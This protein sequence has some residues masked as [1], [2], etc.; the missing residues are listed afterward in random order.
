MR[1]I[2]IAVAF[3]FYV[4]P[5]SAQEATCQRPITELQLAWVTA[6]TKLTAVTAKTEAARSEVVS[7]Y[8]VVDSAIAHVAKARA[9][10][11]EADLDRAVNE[12]S[13]AKKNYDSAVAAERPMLVARLEA[14]RTARGARQAL[15]EAAIN[16]REQAEALIHAAERV[17]GG[18]VTPSLTDKISC[19]Q[20][21]CRS[22]SAVDHSAMIAIGAVADTL[23]LIKWPPPDRLCE[24]TL[25]DVSAIRQGLA[26]SLLAEQASAQQAV[27]E[28]ETALLAARQTLATG[29]KPWDDSIAGVLN[30]HANPASNSH[31]DELLGMAIEDLR[32]QDAAFDTLT[33]PYRTADDA[34]MAARAN[35]VKATSR[36]KAHLDYW[37]DVGRAV[38]V[39][40]ARADRDTITQNLSQ[41]GT[42]Q[43]EILAQAKAW[44][45]AL[46]P[47]PNC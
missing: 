30:S 45:F 37:A 27:Q 1:P 26:R 6:Q 32:K 12:L 23:D 28:T 16:Y 14:E 41:A 24:F 42:C 2:N 5:A 19:E 40:A 43:P 21:D 25:F 34:A 33:E 18:E 11:D 29:I 20:A 46:S 10:Q 4:L 17:K 44:I 39:A 13:T 3:L 15:S 47:P 35:M 31:A 9:A 38:M 22:I 8:R 36:L 7:T